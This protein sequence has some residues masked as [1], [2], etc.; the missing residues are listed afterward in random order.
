MDVADYARIFE[1]V[2]RDI[3]TLRASIKAAENDLAQQNITLDALVQ[4]H[5]ALAPMVGKE[6]IKT[7]KAIDASVEAI[8]S[9][10]ISHAVRQ[11]LDANQLETFTA[12][13]MRDRLAAQGWDWSKYVNPL[14]T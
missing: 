13:V 5:N 7:G 9:A 2:E 3:K 6:P 14:A 10:G 1:K 11:I 4:T 8:T 12:A